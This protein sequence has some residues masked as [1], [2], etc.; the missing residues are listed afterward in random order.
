MIQMNDEEK[1]KEKNVM[2]I[3]GII[4]VVCFFAL[5][6][7]FIGTL[8]SDRAH[9]KKHRAWKAMANLKYRPPKPVTPEPIIY[10][11]K[12]YPRGTLFNGVRVRGELI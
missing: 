8:L 3:A 7:F 11:V 5:A 4:I 10:P 2:I 6:W 9:M 12:T 1:R